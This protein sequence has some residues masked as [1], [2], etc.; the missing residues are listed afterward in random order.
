M[1]T[2]VSLSRKTEFILKQDAESAN[3]TTFLIGVLSYRQRNEIESVLCDAMDLD[4][5]T[6][7]AVEKSGEEGAVSAILS[8]AKLRPGFIK[9][10]RRSQEMRVRYGVKGWSNLLDDE[11]KPVPFTTDKSGAWV[12]AMS[13]ESFIAI[14]PFVD[15]LSEAVD[16][17][18]TLTKATVKN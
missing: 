5:E 9:A 15:E 7:Q 12:G 17:A 14:A 13:E 3:P 1:A 8:K 2:A 18:N 4:S 10:L 16:S 11:G 6:I